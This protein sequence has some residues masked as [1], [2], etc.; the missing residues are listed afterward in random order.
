[1]FFVQLCNYS[2]AISPFLLPW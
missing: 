2:N 1:M